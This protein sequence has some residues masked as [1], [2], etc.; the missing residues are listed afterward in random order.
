MEEGVLDD[1][2]KR[3]VSLPRDTKPKVINMLPFCN[4]KAKLTEQEVLSLC[5]NA[6]EL[7]SKEDIVLSL[8]APINICGDIHGQFFDLLRH[9]DAC[10]FPPHQK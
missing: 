8:S 6:R 9:F 3:L 2:I 10:G 4:V 1:I 7:L 5:F